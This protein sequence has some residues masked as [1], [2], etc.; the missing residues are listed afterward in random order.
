M[1]QNSTAA[2]NTQ[3]T[4]EGEDDASKIAPSDT[5][6]LKLQGR[7]GLNFLSGVMLI[8]LLCA[9]IATAFLWFQFRLVNTELDRTG[10]DLGSALETVRADLSALDFRLEDLIF[11]Q[12]ATS[13]ETNELGNQLDILPG[14]L[15]NLEERLRA[16]Q[17]V[18]EDAR[19][20]WIRAEA[21]YYLGVANAELTIAGRWSSATRALQLADGKLLELANPA[22][23][24]VRQRIAAEL[25][26]LSTIQLPDIEGLTFS[27]S[28]LAESGDTLPLRTD[29][30]G[31]FTS[32]EA[33]GAG[34]PAGFAR[35]WLS[36]KSAVA[37]MISIERHDELI[38]RPLSSEEQTLLRRQFELELTVARVALIRGQ[39]GI[40]RASIE[41]ATGLLRRHF[42]Q[43]A[44]SVVTA[45]NLLDEMVGLTI[46]PEPPNISGS[47]RLLRD[48]EERGG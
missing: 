35:A 11:A 32:E 22:L 20:R 26:V 25:M 15:L 5:N 1:S 47:L 3:N 7:G 12:N 6:S 33:V 28:S 8:C 16:T 30:R 4:A 46:S 10:A 40:F 19:R 2:D 41:T 48:I 31:A 45:I 43:T 24:G 34:V 18:S 36:V 44:A 37:S 21:E 13:K 42:D 9:T 17:G 38:V 27:L 23:S 39:S 29:S 14:R